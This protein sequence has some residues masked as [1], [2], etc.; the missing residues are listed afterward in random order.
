MKKRIEVIESYIEQ[1]HLYLAAQPFEAEIQEIR[2]AAQM[3]TDSDNLSFIYIIDV[4]DQFVYVSVPEK[5]W[6][7]LKEALD[8]EYGVYLKLNNHTLQLESFLDELRYLI[9]NIEG[10]ANYGEKMVSA[11]EEIF[12]AREDES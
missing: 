8:R 2:D 11:V 3:I 5:N 6:S 7:H 10:N 1:E 12:L 9:E 4:N